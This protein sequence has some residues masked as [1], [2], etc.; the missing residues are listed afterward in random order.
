MSDDARDAF[1]EAAEAEL[2][3]VRQELIKAC[4]E[5]DAARAERDEAKRHAVGQHRALTKAEAERDAAVA[6]TVERCAELVE[7]EPYGESV[8]T[9]AARIR[10][11][12]P[13]TP[14]PT[15]LTRE[16]VWRNGEKVDCPACTPGVPAGATKPTYDHTRGD[17]PETPCPACAPPPVA[18]T[19]RRCGKAMIHW[20][21]SESIA[22]SFCSLECMYQ[23]PRTPLEG[24]A[25][26]RECSNDR[27]TW[28]VCLSLDCAHRYSR[29]RAPTSPTE[30]APAT[31][32]VQHTDNCARCGHQLPGQC[33]CPCHGT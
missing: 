9:I 32:E 8:H 15:C 12:T 1:L 27:T 21:K 19:C 24:P 4:R 2:A 6:T 7:G 17:S 28:A 14:C 3:D 10:A 26:D 33:G 5:R 22:G 31:P 30:T 18:K 23:R 11:L 16:K 25:P 20:W 13:P 29:Y